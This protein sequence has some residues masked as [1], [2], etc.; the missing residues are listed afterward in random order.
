MLRHGGRA[1][2]VEP[3]QTALYRLWVNRLHGSHFLAATGE[4]EIGDEPLTVEMVKQNAERFRSV[5]ALRSGAYLRFA[6]IA[7][8]R[9]GVRLPVAAARRALVAERKV[10]GFCGAENSFGNVSVLLEK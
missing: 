3:I 4:Q 7:L 9:V 1:A 8:D 10:F 5:Q 2:F 6:L